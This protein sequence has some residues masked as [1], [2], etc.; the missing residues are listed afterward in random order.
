LGGYAI[1]LAFGNDR[2]R[3]LIS[4]TDADGGPSPFMVVNAAFIHYILLQAAAILAAVIGIVF[5][6]KSGVIAFCGFFL[7]I[8]SLSTSVAAAFAVLNLAEWFDFWAA[9]QTEDE[10]EK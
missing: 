10:G 1:L 7:F 9:K 2:F 6:I 4:G 5:S 8:Y 3:R